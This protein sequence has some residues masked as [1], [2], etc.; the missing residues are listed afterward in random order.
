MR[1]LV[2]ATFLSLAAATSASAELKKLKTFEEFLS[3][4]QGK[5]LT[6]PL[7]K[8]TVTPGRAH[9]RARRALGRR[10][11]LALERRV[12]LPRSLLGR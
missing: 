11:Q 4:V 2:L 6:R 10:R 9:R 5:T 7:I 3:Y 8:L 1:G 12:F